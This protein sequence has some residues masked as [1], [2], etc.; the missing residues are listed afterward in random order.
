MQNK[1]FACLT[2]GLRALVKEENIEILTKKV[3][4]STVLR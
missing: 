4:H 3:E 1:Y 2:S